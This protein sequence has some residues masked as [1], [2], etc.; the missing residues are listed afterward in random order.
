[1]LVLGSTFT[2]KFNLQ[3]YNVS[4]GYGTFLFSALW[5]CELELWPLNLKKWS[6]S[7]T[8]H[9]SRSCEFW[10]CWNVGLFWC[11]R[12]TP[13]ELLRDGLIIVWSIAQLL[14]QLHSLFFKANQWHQI[15]SFYVHATTDE[16]LPAEVLK[17]EK[18]PAKWDQ[19]RKKCPTLFH[20]VFTARVVEEIYNKT[21]AE[22]C[23]LI[24][25]NTDHMDF[26]VL[27]MEKT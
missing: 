16:Q 4:G 26:L 15:N 6:T 20:G 10:T 14:R 12:Q 23:Q 5:P 1:M 13:N 18:L 24:S 17:H 11:Y 8:W 3:P 7:C 9:G 21:A 25:F 2:G 27:L 22:Y 19:K